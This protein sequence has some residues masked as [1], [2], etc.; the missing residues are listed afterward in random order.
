MYICVVVVWMYV[1][2]M[3]CKTFRPTFENVWIDYSPGKWRELSRRRCDIR[4]RGGVLPLV[5]PHIHRDHRRRL[6]S[7]LE[8]DCQHCQHPAMP[9]VVWHF[10]CFT[11]IHTACIHSS[12]Y[13]YTLVLLG[14]RFIGYIENFSNINPLAGSRSAHKNSIV[15]SVVRKNTVILHS[16]TKIKFIKYFELQIPLIS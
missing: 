15:F 13:T 3:D 1:Y 11:H 14:E 2:G 6:I 4:I 12:T 10:H 5:H 8:D 7:N 9:C 16:L